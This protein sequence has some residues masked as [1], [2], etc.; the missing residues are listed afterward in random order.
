MKCPS[1]LARTASVLVLACSAWIGGCILAV[2]QAMTARQAKD[3]QEQAQLQVEI[4][5]TSANNEYAALLED[6]LEMFTVDCDEPI[7]EASSMADQERH[8]LDMVPV[9]FHTA[10][11]DAMERPGYDK[12]VWIELQRKHEDQMHP[13][14]VWRLLADA[15]QGACKEPTP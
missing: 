3:A 7:W 2:H 1:N 15:V 11:G 10:W 13:L 4:A 9:S 6:C 12:P 5:L 8:N 14:G